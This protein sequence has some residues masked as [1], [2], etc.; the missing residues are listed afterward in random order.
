METTQVQDQYIKLLLRKIALLEERL[1]AVNNDDHA[2]QVNTDYRRLRIHLLTVIQKNDRQPEVPVEKEDANEEEEPRYVIIVNKWD[3]DTGEYKDDDITK[4]TKQKEIGP[5]PQSRRAFTF[6]KSTMLRSR[7]NYIETVVSEAKIESESLQR[8]IGT[9]TKGL[10][11]PE[12]VTSLS[13]PFTNLVWT[14]AEADEEAKKYVES[15]TPDE[16]QARVDLRELMRIVSTSSGIQQLDQYFK[17][18]S[19][20]VEEGTISHAAL[21]TL[22]HPGTLI[23]SHPF[24]GEP[25]I[26]T[27]DSCDYFVREEHTF[28]LVCFSFD[29][30]GTEFTRVPFEMKIRHWGSNRK[31]IAELPFYPL[32]YYTSPVDKNV[33]SEDAI[34]QLKDQLIARGKK[35][36]KLC[37]AEKGKQM[38]TYS[39][40]AHFHAGRS[41]INSADDEGMRRSRQDDDSST[42]TDTGAGGRNSEARYVKRK[43]VC[44]CIPLAIAKPNRSTNSKAG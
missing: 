3:P 6:R 26:F 43:K 34:A 14:W 38:R 44:P 16:K 1:P 5:K 8:L 12:L 2:S 37:T 28:D 27:V 10:G 17:E 7:I 20:F 21:W 24:L 18:R 42:S 39:G 31:S 23:V 33:T 32:E 30:A 36:V 11:A 4:S 29:W 15:E 25:Q 40:D 22:F 41:F 19:F 9:I 35:F 13:S